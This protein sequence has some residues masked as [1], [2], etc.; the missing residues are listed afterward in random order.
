MF[1]DIVAFPELKRRRDPCDLAR[2]PTVPDRPSIADRITV[3]GRTTVAD[4]IFV[5]E[6]PV[7]SDADTGLCFV[8][9]TSFLPNACEVI[10]YRVP[11]L[12]C[13]RLCRIRLR[14]K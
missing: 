11:E 10:D 5:G 7:R 9:R 3:T 4:D 2:R 13:A 12:W 8:R 1:A 14:V 6:I